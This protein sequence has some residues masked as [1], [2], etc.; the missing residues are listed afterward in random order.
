MGT[1][2]HV[3]SLYLLNQA[4]LVLPRKK[5][6]TEIMK[7]FRPI[8]LIH[9]LGKLFAKI[10]SSWLAPLMHF[11]VMKNQSV[12]I[13]GKAIH[14]NFKAVQSIAKLL[15]ARNRACILFKIDIA[16]AFDTITWAFL[17]ELLHHLGFSRRWINWVSLLLCTSST[18]ILL[19]GQPGKRIYH[20]RGLRQGDPLY[21]LLFVLVMD[22][23]NA[24]FQ[25]AN[26]RGMFSPLRAHSVYH[27]VS[28]YVDDLVI[29][30]IPTEADITLMRA[31]LQ[32]FARAS[33]LHTNVS[34]CQATPI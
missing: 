10:L 34:K 4:Y 23:L 15:H 13:K 1:S 6:D 30:I 32:A 7:D 24:M 3:T 2:I 26:E 11:L 22:V 9:S 16:K 25:S 8:S 18:R 17:I 31:I 29:F 5:I 19:N 12:S 21:Q 14:D 28:V 20:T 27:R 33:W